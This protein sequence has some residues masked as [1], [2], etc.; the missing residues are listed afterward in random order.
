[1]AQSLERLGDPLGDILALIDSKRLGDLL[2]RMGKTRRTRLLQRLRVPAMGKLTPTICAHALSQLRSA[3][4]PGQRLLD[5]QSLGGPLNDSLAQART[6]W[7]HSHPDSALDRNLEEAPR[8]ELLLA[9]LAF[10][11]AD[12]GQAYMLAW[13][14]RNRALPS[15]PTDQVTELAQACDRLASQWV[16]LHTSTFSSSMPPAADT[17]AG[18]ERENKADV[19]TQAGCHAAAERIQRLLESAVSSSRRAADALG[20]GNLPEPGAWQPVQELIELTGVLRTALAPYGDQFSANPLDRP[21]GLPALEHQL[22]ERAHALGVRGDLSA[23]IDRI[24][25]VKAVQP[26]PAIEA[27]LSQAEQLRSAAAWQ[28]SEVTLATLLKDIVG[29]AD[30]VARDDDQSVERLDSRL[31]GALPDALR[32]VVLLVVRGKATFP[33]GS[34]ASSTARE[35]STFRGGESALV[36]S[37]PGPRA[38]SVTPEARE[39]EPP[40][41]PLIAES[42]ETRKLDETDGLAASPA[43]RPAEDLYDDTSGSTLA[44]GSQRDLKSLRVAAP[45]APNQEGSS[46]LASVPRADLGENPPPTDTRQAKPERPE[47]KALVREHNDPSCQH[48]LEK[49]AGHDAPIA[50]EFSHPPAHVEA[51]TEVQVI[52]DALAQGEAALAHHTARAANRRELASSLKMFVLAE[53]MRTPTGACADAFHNEAATWQGE[54]AP[55]L[56]QTDQLLRA[57]A[58][59]RVCLVSG[60]PETGEVLLRLSE[61]LH[62]MPS[63]RTT[64]TIVAETCARG[65]L[66]AQV[67]GPGPEASAGPADVD[68][69]SVSA[70]ARES[71]AEQRTLHFP[72]ANEIVREWWSGDGL[73]GSLLHSVAD[74]DRARLDIVRAQLL[75]LRKSEAL[76]KKLTKTD[77]ERREKSSARLQGAA[78]RRILQYA[79]ESLEI[80]HG[81]LVAVQNLAA[82][83]PPPVFSHL[84]ARLG[85]SSTDLASELNAL[86]HSAG[87]SPDLL[88][89]VTATLT[90]ASVRRST[91]LLTAGRLPGPE[92][93]PSAALNI[94]L[95][96]CAALE[97]DT[98]L[99]P[100][101]PVTIEDVSQALGCGWESAAREHAAAENF[102]TARAALEMFEL[103][104]GRAETVSKIREEHHRL[105]VGSR[106]EV[107]ALHQGVKHRAE[108]ASRLGQLPEPG[109]SRVTSRLQAAEQALVGDNN[110]GTIRRECEEIVNLL[111]VYSE[112]ARNAFQAAAAQQLNNLGAST[113]VADRIRELI[114]QG[115][116]ATAEE[117]LI[118]AREGFEL[119]TADPVTDFDEF[120]PAVCEALQA[121]I[122]PELIRQAANGGS[123]QGL[124]F[125]D[126]A[127]AQRSQAADA[128]TALQQLHSQWGKFRDAK[129]HLKLAL[130]LAGIEYS[131]EPDPGLT[132]PLT[133]RWFDITDVKLVGPCRLPQFGSDSDGRLRVMTTRAI[134][135]VR[136]LFGWIQQDVSQLPVLV[137]VAGVMS[138]AQRR[139]LAREC[140]T[141]RDK[142]VLVLDAAALAFLAARGTG[143]FATTER[144][145]APFS[146]ITPYYP[147]ASDT[148]PAE[149][150][151][152]R[153]EELS[154]VLDPQGSS[155]LYGGRR[156]GK[157]ALLKAAAARYRQTRHHLSL[158]IPLPSGMSLTPKDIWD[159]VARSLKQSGIAE[160]RRQRAT[161]MHQVEDDITRWL[162]QDKARKLLILFDECDEFFDGDAREN[163]VHTTALRNLMSSSERRFKPVF[164]GLH[165]V[166]RFAS[167]PNQ[168]LAGAHFGEPMVIGPLSPGAAYRLLHEPMQALGIRFQ[169]DTLI[170]RALAYANYHPKIIQHIGLALVQETHSRRAPA[171]GPPWTI[172]EET[173]ERV[174]GSGALAKS[175]RDTV[176]LTLHLDPRY[177]LIALVLA[178]HAYKH[179][180]DQPI[181]GRDLRTEC[182]EWWP[183]ALSATP[184]DEYRALLEEMAG[185]GVLAADATGWRL[186]SSNVLLLLGSPASIEEEL[187]AQEDEAVTALSAAHARRTLPDNRI[188]PLTEAQI[189]DLTRR[190]NGLRIVVGPPA[191]GLEDVVMALTEQQQR[192]PTRIATL[193]S[194]NAP[195]K[196]RTALQS[197]RAG[198]QHRIIISDMR[199]FGA[200]AL[201]DSLDQALA[202]QPPEGVSRCVVALVDPSRIDHLRELTAADEENTVLLQLATT[203]GLRS[204]T[205]NQDPMAPY[206]DPAQRAALLKA[207]GGWPSLLNR[208]LALAVKGLTP[209]KALAQL[210]EELHGVEGTR[211]LEATGL[212]DAVELHPLVDQLVDFDAPLPMEDLT[213]LLQTLHPDIHLQLTALRRMNVLDHVGSEGLAMEPVVAAAWRRHSPS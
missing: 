92:S 30:A 40:A 196:Y 185:L 109:R 117:F 96:R 178:L 162:Q 212:I 135:D 91:T 67:L 7:L 50:A 138:V 5:A 110:L 83:T 199:R 23:S 143:L 155:I 51:S 62:E 112:Q 119:P 20:S 111:D 38:E 187:S 157:S 76:E 46:G 81:W 68:V 175:I 88:L 61:S 58:C 16:E 17:E 33:A 103:N 176:R 154:A 1:M 184:P 133:R 174:I 34:N 98:D 84:A 82:F 54:A 75:E 171:D 131:D 124:D 183:K 129:K 165:Q 158:Y 180:V 6:Q 99:N 49:S 172:D 26:H 28:T 39:A 9:A 105:R 193:I 2:N 85:T 134:S 195:N 132:T 137:V 70:H 53:G 4:P 11:D 197:G 13:S 189:A 87:P 22:R 182:V 209:R 141:R 200:N 80:V 179:G 36:P 59:L 161:T 125:S 139:A 3:R 127:S 147:E 93:T 48:D 31:R 66:T 104:G 12:P 144:I 24:A 32:P 97:F 15:W 152:G 126:L 148:L 44:P 142:P 169:S 190:R 192:V 101:R 181:A 188:S 95:L 64:L 213:D 41:P 120:F 29:L 205:S 94:D 18:A 25:R 206:S 100:L 37:V 56:D 102:D 167:L 145:L 107:N 8:D 207:T 27:L 89:K 163:F 136:T 116:L 149:M 79:Q 130:R 204:W 194:P 55:E 203:D 118:A 151:Y 164:A 47:S 71:L 90:L 113:S 153:S 115:D 69:T 168:P 114:A 86:G 63:L 108:T 208:M 166:Q 123:H 201:R 19:D 128:L 73:I 211:L 43:A 52:V 65:Q 72:R 170:H 191:A 77:S 122:T 156:L 177:K 74:D 14:L 150:F 57:A 10:W 106:Q 159:L 42:G 121:G 202:L 186:R 198:R 78:R 173:L 45:Q 21:Q 146:A 160:H 35:D 60:S 140:V 210:A